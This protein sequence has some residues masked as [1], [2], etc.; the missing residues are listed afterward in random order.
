MPRRRVWNIIKRTCL[1]GTG[2]S[3][4]LWAA[5][6]G[7]SVE[8]WSTSSWFFGV[9]RGC[10]GGGDHAFMHTQPGFHADQL[11]MTLWWTPVSWHPGSRAWNL[12]VPWWFV[13]LPLGTVGGVLAWRDFR[14]PREGHCVCG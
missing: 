3:L 6:V 13:V 9:Q 1:M 5:S 2:V 10:F 7:R 8:Y 11:D 4:L 12:W 14:R